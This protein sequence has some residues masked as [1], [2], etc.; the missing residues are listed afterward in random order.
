M[1]GKYPVV[2]ATGV[3]LEIAMKYLVSLQKELTSAEKYPYVDAARI[4]KEKFLTEKENYE[5]L[6]QAEEEI[7]HKRRTHNNSKKEEF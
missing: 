2:K 6:H 5:T 4:D 3:E 7:S 1:K